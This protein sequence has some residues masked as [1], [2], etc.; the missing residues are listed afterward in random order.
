MPSFLSKMESA[1]P[2][3]FPFIAD[4]FVTTELDP[5]VAGLDSSGLDPNVAELDASGLD[6]SGLN[7]SGFDCAACGLALGAG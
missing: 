7:A 5:T 1:P 2:F 6:A 3:C 4:F